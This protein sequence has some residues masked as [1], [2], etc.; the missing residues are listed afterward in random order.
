MTNLPQITNATSSANGDEPGP[1]VWWVWLAT[2]TFCALTVPYATNFIQWANDF[3]VLPIRP[4][5]YLVLASVACLVVTFGRRPD[6]TV[7]SL[8]ILSFQLIYIFE[9]V[10]LHRYDHPSGRYYPMMTHGAMFVGIFSIAWF[11]GVSHRLSALPMKMAA[12][13]IVVICSLANIA[14]WFGV[15]EFTIV[16]GR[17]AGFHGDPNNASIAIVLALAVFLS[18]SKNIWV[19]FAMIALSFIAVAITLSRSGMIAEVLVSVA[20]LVSA[21]RRQPAA[22][23]QALAVTVPIVILGIGFLISQMSTETLRESDVQD[24]LGALLG[25]DSGKMASG[26][27]MKDLSDGLRAIREQPVFGYGV[28][29]GTGKWQPHNQLVAVWIDGGIIFAGLYLAI[30]ASMALKCLMAGGRGGLCLLAVVIFI[31]FSQLLHTSM[32]YWTTC[33][34]FI[35]LTST[36]FIT[37]QWSG[38]SAVGQ[39]VSDPSPSTSQTSHA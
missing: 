28:G 27:R 25:K 34:V 4:A 33:I 22:V 7:T 1:S 24:R 18:Y 31:P 8:L 35:N 19:S 39:T 30:L 12:A 29:T 5:I 15:H 17:A 10:V 20:F 23:L 37:L 38:S 11:L 13:S 6:L 3:G 26:E 14:E 2:A 36:R 9:S 21:Y 32:A 16:V